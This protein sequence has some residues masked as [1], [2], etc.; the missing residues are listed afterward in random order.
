MAVNWNIY[1]LLRRGARLDRCDGIRARLIMLIIYVYES[2]IDI[3]PFLFSKIMS[4]HTII[5]FFTLIFQAP[6]LS[7]VRCAK[8]QTGTR[9]SWSGI[10]LLA[11]RSFVSSLK[12]LPRIF[13]MLKFTL[14]YL[15]L[16]KFS[17]GSCED[18]RYLL[19]EGNDYL[20]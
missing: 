20:R 7:S 3:A 9:I 11:T 13:T 19:T 6:S 17:S 14:M 8:S 12:L 2:K 4:S 18:C 15:H 1:W 5:Q 10:M 16:L